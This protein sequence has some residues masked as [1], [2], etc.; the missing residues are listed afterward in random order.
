MVRAL[1][2]AVI[3]VGEGRAPVEWPAQV[4][5]SRARHPGVVVMPAHG[6]SLEEVTY[7]PDVEVGGRAMAVRV[8]RTAHD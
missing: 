5:V 3:P 8:R 2:G 6:L 7:P 1:V 4:L